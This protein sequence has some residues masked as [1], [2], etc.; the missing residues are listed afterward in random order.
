M[1]HVF[2]RGVTLHVDQ[3]DALVLTGREEASSIHCRNNVHYKALVVENFLHEFVLSGLGA[4]CVHLVREIDG[5]RHEHVGAALDRQTSD[6]SSVHGQCLAERVLV[7]NHCLRERIVHNNILN[8]SLRFRFLNHLKCASFLG[9][10]SLV[11][12]FL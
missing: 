6:C 2:K 11:R 4:S 1:A 7:V 3:D 5:S 10:F 8:S 12:V 9:H